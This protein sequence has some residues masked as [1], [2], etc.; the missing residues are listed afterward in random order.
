M[1]F[2]PADQRIPE[3]PLWKFNA[4]FSGHGIL[5][6]TSWIITLVHILEVADLGGI[7]PMEALLPQLQLQRDIRLSGIHHRRQPA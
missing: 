2:T 7:L 6:L 5:I 3:D 1:I 4:I